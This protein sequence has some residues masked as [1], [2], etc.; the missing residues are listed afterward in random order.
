MVKYSAFAALADPTRRAMVARLAGGGELTVG[1]LAAAAPT[2]L[3]P[4]AVSK[5]VAVLE[6][7]GLVERRR[8]GRTHRCRLV[9]A[10]LDEAAEWLDERRRTWTSRLERLAAELENETEN[11]NETRENPS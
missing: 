9:T 10:P 4:P 6:R 5:H 2:P 3:T 1:E 7:A 8:V 11:E